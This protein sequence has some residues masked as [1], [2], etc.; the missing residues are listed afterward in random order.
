LLLF[1]VV[2]VV[3]ALF[4]EQNDLSSGWRECLVSTG[5][6]TWLQ[7]QRE[8]QPLRVSTLAECLG[9][10]LWRHSVECS[11]YR[12][13]LKGCWPMLHCLDS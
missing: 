12:E 2:V 11:D 9:F 6:S 7:S 13:F 8:Y 1:V 5:A 10:D 4:F 3:V